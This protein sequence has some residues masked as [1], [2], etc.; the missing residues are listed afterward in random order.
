MIKEKSA[1]AVVFRKDNEIKYLLLYR[2]AKL[3]YKESWDFPKGKIEEEDEKKTIKREILEET[4][5]NDV[6]IIPS[7]KEKISYFYK[8]E[9][10]LISKEVVYYLVETKEEKVNISYEHDG[11]KWANY[12]EAIKLLTFDNAK[13]ILKKADNFLIKGR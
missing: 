4:G 9:S 11:Y 2:K 7:F 13:N 12:N 6:R 3:H 8:K 10:K 1:G 5:I